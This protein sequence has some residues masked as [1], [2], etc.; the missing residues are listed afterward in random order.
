MEMKP[1][2]EQDAGL[3]LRALNRFIK[4]LESPAALKLSDSEENLRKV[5]AA[6]IVDAMANGKRR[7]TEVAASMLRHLLQEHQTSPMTANMLSIQLT[8]Y[9]LGL[10]YA[11]KDS[12]AV[13]HFMTTLNETLTRVSVLAMLVSQEQRPKP[14]DCV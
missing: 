1:F 13:L 11:Q 7:G 5:W 9:L 6:E 14:E 10:V 8:A 4:H 12:G 3:D 2:T